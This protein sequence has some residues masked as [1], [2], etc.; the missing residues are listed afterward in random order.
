MGA[1]VVHFEI[2]GGKGNELETF[3]SA[4]FGWKIKPAVLRE[5]RKQTPDAVWDR[6][7]QV[8]TC[9]DEFIAPAEGRLTWESMSL[10]QLGKH[11]K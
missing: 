10:S 6:R 7:E 11:E 4:L 9:R 1:P 3:Y 5:F 8:W 2:M